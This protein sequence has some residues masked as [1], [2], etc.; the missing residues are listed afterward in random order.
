MIKL[1][2]KSTALVAID[3]HRGH[4]D[5]EVATLPLPAERCQ[6]L[7]DR[8]GA[9]FDQLRE[10]GVPIIHVVSEYRDA[11]ELLSNPFWKHIHDDPTKARKGVSRHNILGNPQVEVIPSL[12]KDGDIIVHSKKRYS[13]FLHTDL[14]F[15]LDRKLGVDTVIICGVNTTSCILCACF[16]ATNLDYRVV[17]ASDACDTVDGPDA[18][19]FALK[20]MSNITGFPMASEELLAAFATA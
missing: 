20:L 2:P 8:A 16:E 9:L 11:S 15:V 5:P 10:I 3:L 12:L 13:S 19:E 4:I 1:D 14:Q 7:I 17:I 18:H 6:P